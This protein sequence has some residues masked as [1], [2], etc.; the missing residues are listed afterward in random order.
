MEK[1]NVN[2]KKVGKEDYRFLYQ[3]LKNRDLH[4][5]ISHKDMPSYVSHI[6]FVE[7]KPYSNWY[8]IKNGKEKVGSIYLSKNDEVGLFLKDGF[9]RRNIGSIALNLMIKKNPRDR[10]LSNI[11]PKNKNAIKFFKKNN[12]KLIQYTF[13]N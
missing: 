13:M 11:N 1:H 7:S 4:T 8:V 9:R 3:L 12:F 6:K 5:S 10:Y 2:L